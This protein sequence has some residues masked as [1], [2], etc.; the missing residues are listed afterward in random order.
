MQRVSKATNRPAALCS[1]GG[2]GCAHRKP[3]DYLLFFVKTN[4]GSE[5]KIRALLQVVLEENRLVY[6]GTGEKATAGE[7]TKKGSAASMSLCLSNWAQTSS[8]E[9]AKREIKARCAHTHK[10]LCAETM[11]LYKLF[12]SWHR[13]ATA[14]FVLH[15]PDKRIRARDL[16]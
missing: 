7:Q 2:A 3:R 16:I 8:K 13:Q 12:A 6:F 5:W 15:S 9:L 4:S 11:H 1:L 14:L 10:N